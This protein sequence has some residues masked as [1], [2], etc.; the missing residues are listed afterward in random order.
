MY[1]GRHANQYEVGYRSEHIEYI[2]PVDRFD[3]Y[4]LLASVV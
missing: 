4:S 1:I 3:C 2:H